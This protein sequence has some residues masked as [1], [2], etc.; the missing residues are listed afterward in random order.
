VP[1]FIGN[2]PNIYENLQLL[3]IVTDIW[4]KLSS[5]EHKKLLIVTHYWQLFSQKFG[6]TLLIVTHYRRNP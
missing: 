4:Q 6:E 5:V 3:V 1:N 2:L